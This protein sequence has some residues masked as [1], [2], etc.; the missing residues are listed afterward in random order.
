MLLLCS[1][2]RTEKK[3]GLRSSTEPNRSPSE[4]PSVSERALHELTRNREG[5]RAPYELTLS[6][7]SGP[8]SSHIERAGT[9]FAISTVL[10]EK[11]SCYCM[12]HIVL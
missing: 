12:F 10:T 8:L 11:G 1:I 5:S 9:P 2:N 4:F 7:V 6:T 3:T